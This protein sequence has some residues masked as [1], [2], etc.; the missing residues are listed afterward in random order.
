LPDLI[1]RDRRWC[2]GN[3]QHLNLV[4]TRGLHWMSRFHL[5]QGAL[6]YVMSPLWLLFLIV[7]A[8]LA[9]QSRVAANGEWDMYG[10]RVLSWVL[11]TTFLCLFVPRIISVGLVLSR[12]AER[13]AWGRPDRLIASVLMETALSA[14]VAPIMMLSQTAALVDILRGRDSGWTAQKRHD[15]SIVWRDAEK[16]HRAHLVAGA[17]LGLFL[18]WVSPSTFLWAIPVVGG[19]LLAAPLAVLSADPAIG[20]WFQRQ[21]LF[22]TPEELAQTSRLAVADSPVLE[23]ASPYGAEMEPTA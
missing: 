20:A 2:Q 21:G 13:R 9:M 6:G 22:A 1:A 4:T 7:S 12:S 3:V 23:G 18:A 19:L 17:A 11:T 8:L 16:R 15:G 14:L 10:I 5:I